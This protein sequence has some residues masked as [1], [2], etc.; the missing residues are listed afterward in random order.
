MQPYKHKLQKHHQRPDLMDYV[1]LTSP[2][3]KVTHTV[4][5]TEEHPVNLDLQLLDN[6]GSFYSF[7]FLDINNYEPAKSLI[8]L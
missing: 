7:V 6:K 1:H 2:A 5:G 4:K 8:Q 3:D